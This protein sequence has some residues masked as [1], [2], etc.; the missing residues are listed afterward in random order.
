MAGVETST[1]SP[2]VG[3]RWLRPTVVLPAVVGAGFAVL[4]AVWLARL[5]VP[6]GDWAVAELVVRHTSRVIPLSGPY[7]AAR[8]YNHP[9]PLVYALQ[10]LPYRMFAQR[11]SAGLATTLWWNGTWLAVLLWMTARIRAPWLGL[12]A[13][14]GVVVMSA[15]TPSGSLLMPWNPTLAVVPAVVLVFVAWRVALGSRRSV[16]VMAGLGVWCVGAHLGFAPFVAPLGL[17]S[18]VSLVIV[19]ARRPDTDSDRRGAD[20]ARRWNWSAVSGLWRPLL[21]GVGVALVLV[22]PMIVDVATNRGESNPANI[23]RNGRL[24]DGTVR[25]SNGELLKVFTAELALPPA[26]A[27][28]DPPY[29]YVMRVSPLR[30]P[31]VALVGVAA[32][33]LAWRRRAYDELAGMGLAVTA[34]GGA[35]AGLA[36][37][38]AGSILPW[39]LLPAHAASIALYAFVAW[40]TARSVLALVDSL[41]PRRT[42]AKAPSW[43]AP[44]TALVLVVLVAPTLRLDLLTIDTDVA[45][46][47]LLAGATEAVPT[48]APVEL[49]GPVNYDGFYTAALA[50]ALDR[51]GYDVR[52]PDD[53]LY[54]FTDAMRAPREWTPTRLLVQFTKGG[55]VAPQP[56]ARLLAQSPIG[57]M[58]FVEADR[59]SLWEA[60]PAAATESA[61]PEPT[62]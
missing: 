42:P 47:D 17:I 31:W 46:A 45:V 43:L 2:D 7:S 15:K 37:I 16:P 5:W 60:P 12:A 18:L 10:W 51:E 41:L 22:S 27:T 56:G 33:A 50:L 49:V 13:F 52:V 8:G 57:D 61:S 39:Y 54:I 29:T 3:R 4:G 25:V 6:N 28:V 30:F 19:T 9:L 53:Q 24:E 58:I 55:L 26:W 23:V 44:V 36:N 1:T 32:A 48:G 11:S 20:R 21:A 59:I 40:S 14:A 62:P 35:I 38:G 34:L